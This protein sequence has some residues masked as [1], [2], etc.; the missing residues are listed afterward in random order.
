MSSTLDA[1]KAALLD[2]LF[3]Q[4]KNLPP[5][6]GVNLETLIRGYYRHVSAVDLIDRTS[7]DLGATVLHHL[8]T[9]S[10]RPQGTAV[11]R[12]VTPLH[13]RDGWSL[14]GRTVVEVVTDDMPFLVDSVTMALDGLGHDV[15]L[16]MHPQFVVRRDLGGDLLE[17]LD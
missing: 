11:V 9:A 16:V 15:H 14:N 7:R 5:M 2:E 4:A 12:L 8:D 17:L 3:A 10:D 1:R 6:P 13:D